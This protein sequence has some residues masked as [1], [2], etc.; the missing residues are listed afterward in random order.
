MAQIGIGDALR[1]V[2]NKFN[3]SFKLASVIEYMIIQR[4]NVM[5]GYASFSKIHWLPWSYQMND[6]QL[7]TLFKGITQNDIISLFKALNREYRKRFGDE[8]YKRMF[9]ALDSTSIS[10][11]S[12]KLSYAEY[13]HNKDGDD[14]VT[15]SEKMIHMHQ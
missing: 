12:T 7:N 4:T 14:I 6:T 3:R 11:Y 8:F 5:H 10:T 15:T 13:G 1:Q 2:F 9:L